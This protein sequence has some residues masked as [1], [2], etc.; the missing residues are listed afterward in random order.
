MA[1]DEL[2]NTKYFT[3]D[4]YM[5]VSVVINDL[6]SASTA[7]PQNILIRK[8][9]ENY[10]IKLFNDSKKFKKGGGE[11]QIEYSVSLK[12]FLI[13]SKKQSLSR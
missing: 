11:L 12:D 3:F 13:L 2:E 1:S 10:S 7:I 9:S 4:E 5:A 6:S 8:N